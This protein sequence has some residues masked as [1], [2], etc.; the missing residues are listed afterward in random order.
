MV[1]RSSRFLLGKALKQEAR[2]S[3]Q[4]TYFARNRLCGIASATRSS[5]NLA[6]IVATQ[7]N[8]G[9]ESSLEWMKAVA[10]ITAGGALV[11]NGNA[12]LDSKTD[13]CGIVGVVGSK[14][15]DAR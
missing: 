8:N 2:K 1:G 5:T 14:E 12:K 11:A 9:G 4:C 10:V 13:C 6:P 3:V 7:S 15:N